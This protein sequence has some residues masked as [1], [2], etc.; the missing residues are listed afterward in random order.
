MG[1]EGNAGWAS[2]RGHAIG[3]H[4]DH[5]RGRIVPLARGLK[6]AGF[7]KSGGVGLQSVNRHGPFKS[8]HERA[9]LRMSS[10]AVHPRGCTGDFGV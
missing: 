1:R 3:T 10:L 9:T 2:N 8:M 5:P 6:D 7:E 4:M